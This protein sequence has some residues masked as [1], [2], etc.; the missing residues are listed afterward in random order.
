MGSL[1]VAVVMPQ[2]VRDGGQIRIPVTAAAAVDPTDADVF[3]A[4]MHRHWSPEL[5]LCAAVLASAVLDV[6][7]YPPDTRPYREAVAWFSSDTETGVHAFPAICALLGY[8]P[9]Y[10]RSRVLG[11]EAGGRLERH[12]LH[13]AR[14]RHARALSSSRGSQPHQ[15]V[16]R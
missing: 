6:R 11:G 7:R 4:G 8:D 9:V 16:R 2:R 12:W 10:V 14:T 5:R 13:A 15:S 3:R 1:P